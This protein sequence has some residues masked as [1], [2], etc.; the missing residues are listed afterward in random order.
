[1]ESVI[2][3]FKKG[4]KTSSF[5]DKSM[6]WV[7]KYKSSNANGRE[8]CGSNHILLKLS[9]A[10]IWIVGNDVIHQQI[11]YLQVRSYTRCVAYSLNKS[12]NSS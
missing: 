12:L 1:M 3:I 9:F 8:K 6:M 2:L 5:Y 4:L 11:Q 7:L 10:H